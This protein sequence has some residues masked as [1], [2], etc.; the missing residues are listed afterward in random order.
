MA[1][2]MEFPASFAYYSNSKASSNVKTHRKDFLE[3]ND[4]NKS[5]CGSCKHLFDLQLAKL[6]RTAKSNMAASYF[7]P[8]SSLAAEIWHNMF[9]CYAIYVDQISKR[10]V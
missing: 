9:Y 7:A 4:C 10:F 2:I 1:A 5:H 8:F 3:A 6:Y